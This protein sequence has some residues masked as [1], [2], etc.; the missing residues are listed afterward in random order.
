MVLDYLGFHYEKLSTKNYSKLKRKAVIMK[1]NIFRRLLCF[2]KPEKQ[3]FEDYEIF[4]I[5][6]GR[7]IVK[8][9]AKENNMVVYDSV[10][11]YLEPYDETRR[12][13]YERFR[14]LMKQEIILNILRSEFDLDKF[15]RVGII[16]D[17]FP[18][19]HYTERDTIIRYWKKWAFNALVNPVNPFQ[20]SP[21]V[22]IPVVQ[23][24]YY[25]GI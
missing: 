21:K 14:D 19:H 1:G 7:S 22:Y 2:W 17:H 8:K 3:D 9:F 25:H 13:H 15:H 11:N 6:I 18:L 23:I 24:G 5:H 10:G 16:I 20:E 12:A 4:V